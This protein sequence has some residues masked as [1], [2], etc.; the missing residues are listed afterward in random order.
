LFF[1][2]VVAVLGTR[3]MPNQ[4]GTIARPT[5]IVLA[6][7]FAGLFIGSLVLGL[8]YSTVISFFL[9]KRPGESAD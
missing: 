3:W 4:P 6:Q 8:I 1:V 9:A 7:A 5:T 2:G